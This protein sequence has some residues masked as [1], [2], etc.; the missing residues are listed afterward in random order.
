MSSSG[1]DP[2]SRARMG[3]VL[4]TFFRGV[5]WERREPQ[6]SEANESV[7]TR[8]DS[9]ESPDQLEHVE[10]E[11]PST[12]REQV[13]RKSEYDDQPE[14]REGHAAAVLDSQ[15]LVWG[16]AVVE[17]ERKVHYMLNET[18]WSLNL[19]DNAWSRRNAEFRRDV[20]VPIPSSASKIAV[21]SNR[22][23]YHYGGIHPSRH[24]L[25]SVAYT[26]N[27]H[28]LDPSTFE[29]RI[30]RRSS[31][32]PH[33][34]S[35][36]G[37]C[38]L[39]DEGNRVL[40]VFGGRGDKISSLAP[41]AA[42][43][44]ATGLY[45]AYNG[46]NNEL[47]VFSLSDENWIPLKCNGSRPL[48]RCG[49][50]FT[51]IDKN[52]AVLIGGLDSQGPFKDAFIFKLNTKEFVRITKL[53]GSFLLP[54][55]C[56]HSAV[57]VDVPGQGALLFVMCGYC[58]G[59]A[60]I[61][62][63]IDAMKCRELSVSDDMISTRLQSVCFVAFPDSVCFIRFGGG[64]ATIKYHLLES[65][66]LLA[67][68]KYEF[69]SPWRLT[70]VRLDRPIVE[71]GSTF[72]Q[73]E[74]P[75][76]TPDPLLKISES[77]IKYDEDTDLLGSGGSGE[78][79]RAK[80]TKSNDVQS[81]AIKVFVKGRRIVPSQSALLDKEA[82]ILLS[83]KPH[84]HILSLIGIC[85]SPRC[86]ALVMEY[87]SG[88][89]LFQVLTSADD[90]SI[91]LWEN[92]L[93]IANQIAL[94]M[95]HLHKN[96]PTVIHLDLKSNNVLIKKITREGRTIYI[97]KICDFGLAKMTDVS[98]VTQ[99]REKDQTPG[100]TAMYIAPERY[101]SVTYGTENSEEKREVA[102]KSDIFSYGILLWEIKERDRPYKGGNS[103]AYE[104]RRSTSRGKG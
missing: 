99:Y 36:C 53:F 97:C 39:G 31:P 69:D 7:S 72:K 86:Y 13:H 81:V 75:E 66:P 43:F 27:L 73:E 93:D 96:E 38:L 98:S 87:I 37:L 45:R 47:W 51:S 21:V 64:A 29:W 44:P 20:D 9:H 6:T 77:E 102:K 50:T 84:P 25:G 56:Y 70:N 16:G 54:S 76:S 83:I 68:A 82:R 33:G 90:N 5:L 17:S 104:D 11:S 15:M 63:E 79:Y 23:I 67:I 88:G 19:R 80:L 78:V 74:I 3:G 103:L 32:W 48:P 60:C 89:D 22:C 71:E 55:F 52:R 12:I 35:G 34:R 41:G 46:F 62:F 10:T 2:V 58:D 24:E 92:R 65:I 42:W 30:V 28:T 26:S 18:I 59:N 95:S 14:S 1:P 4:E 40:V 49:H 57:A 101:Q 100:G 85:T 94:G 91:E 8:A 61:V